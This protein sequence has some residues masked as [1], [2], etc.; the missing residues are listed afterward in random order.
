[1][2]NLWFEFE[3]RVVKEKLPLIFDKFWRELPLFAPDQVDVI[4]T[5]HCQL[6]GGV[7]YVNFFRFTGD[8]LA[9]VIIKKSGVIDR[10]DGSFDLIYLT[11]C[12]GIPRFFAPKAKK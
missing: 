2:S 3:D 10:V 5:E 9:T 6:L 4:L 7:G 11:H 8:R 1:M 12:G